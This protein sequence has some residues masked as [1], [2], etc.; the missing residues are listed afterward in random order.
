MGVVKKTKQ[1][2]ISEAPFWRLH[3]LSKFRATVV[4]KN[5][6]VKKLV[7]FRIFLMH[8]I[9]ELLLKV[10]LLNTSSTSSHKDNWGNA[11]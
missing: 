8:I 6:A 1:K 3:R 11:F 9:M 2:L 4:L 7:Q 5:T 10:Y